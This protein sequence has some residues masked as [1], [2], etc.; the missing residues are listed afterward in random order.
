M[1]KNAVS[2]RIEEEK[3]EELNELAKVSKRDRSFI[4]NEAIDLYLEMNKWQIERIKAAVKEA[5]QG[6]FATAS[7]LSKAMKRWQK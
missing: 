5:D 7:E 2:I 3:V 1:G 4:I 6:K